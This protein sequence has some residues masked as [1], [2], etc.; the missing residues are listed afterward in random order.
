[1]IRNAN[2]RDYLGVAQVED[3]LRINCS[4]SHVYNKIRCG[5][6]KWQLLTQPVKDKEGDQR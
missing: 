5:K 1:M 2:F 6:E 4:L 3:K